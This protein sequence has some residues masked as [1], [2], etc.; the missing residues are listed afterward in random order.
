MGINTAQYDEL[1]RRLKTACNLDAAVAF[2][3]VS[4]KVLCQ[5]VG[6]FK[7][8]RKGRRG[9]CK[10]DLLGRAVHIRH[11]LYTVH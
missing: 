7:S 1:E 9:E 3:Q 10:V 5:R 8:I 6:P 11:V 2:F 4:W